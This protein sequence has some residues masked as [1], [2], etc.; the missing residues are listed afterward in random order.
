MRDNIITDLQT[1]MA[2]VD[3]AEILREMKERHDRTG[4]CGIYDITSDGKL[5]EKLHDL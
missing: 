2:N 3:V 1:E 4:E 5:G